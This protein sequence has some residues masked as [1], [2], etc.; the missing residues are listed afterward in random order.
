MSGNAHDEFADIGPELSDE[1]ADFVGAFA[2]VELFLLLC[3]TL[4][5]AP[6]RFISAHAAPDL[7]RSRTGQTHTIREAAGG[8]R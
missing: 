4:L 8:R 5:S 6:L 3:S 2:S 7:R 1:F